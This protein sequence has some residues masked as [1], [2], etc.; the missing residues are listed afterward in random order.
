LGLICIHRYQQLRLGCV[1]GDG[2]GVTVQPTIRTKDE[3]QCILKYVGIS[4]NHGWKHSEN[5]DK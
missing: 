4:E 5:E 1:F 2:G 3:S